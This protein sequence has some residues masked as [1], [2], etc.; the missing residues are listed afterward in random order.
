[1]CVYI[2]IYIYIY[3]PGEVRNENLTSLLRSVAWLHLPAS[4]WL[5][6]PPV[7]FCLLA[8]TC[9]RLPAHRPIDET[10]QPS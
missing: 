8:L 5:L 9:I 1:M 7:C 10:D 4:T 3:I 6:D 2:Y